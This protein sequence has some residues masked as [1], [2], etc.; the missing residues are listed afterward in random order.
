M[1]VAH[2]TGL[3]NSRMNN[4]SVAKWATSPLVVAVGVVVLVVLHLAH[5]MIAGQTLRAILG[6][7]FLNVAMAGAVL[8][9]FLL[10]IMKMDR[11]WSFPW[12]HLGAF[13]VIA[14]MFGLL[15]FGHLPHRVLAFRTHR[16][17]ARTG[18]LP[19]L[20][21][22]AADV[23]AR[24]R[25]QMKEH[26]KDRWEVPEESYSEQVR[27]LRPFGVFIARVFQGGQ[28]GLC[29]QYPI[30]HGD[31]L[32]IRVGPPGAVP[33]EHEDWAGDWWRCDDGLYNW[34]F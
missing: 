20:Q 19:A 17:V 4:T 3:K 27:R 34:F 14:V 31:G 15:W 22:W 23:V 1:R 28:E 30:P 18:G 16:M 21:T 9:L 24:P 8:Y 6:F 5:T 2:P 11:H 25:N 10:A 26:G 13:G 29:L 12:A 32:E 33:I 7:G